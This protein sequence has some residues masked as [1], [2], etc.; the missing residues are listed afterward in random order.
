MKRA[1]A[2]LLCM[3]LA[4]ADF[5]NAAKDAGLTSIV[6]N[7]GTTSKQFIIE[8]TGSGVAF[9]DYDNDGLQDIFV[10]SG[11]DAPSRMYHNEGGGKFRDVT[12][13]L[14]LTRKGWGQGVCAGDFDNDGFTDIFV[15]Y[16]GQNAL[17]HNT[18][19][20]HFEDVTA[21]AHL[22]QG[23]ARYN[24][25]CAFLDY[26]ND[27]KLDLFVSNYLKFDFN[28]TPKPGANPYCFY[29]GIAVNC[30]PRGL[31][32]DRNLLYHSEGG[33]LFK[34]VSD[35]SGMS[36]PD[37]NYSLGVLTADFNGDGLTDIYVACDQTPSILY[38][39]LGNG[40]FAD[41]ALMRGTALDENG[42]AMSGMGVAAA[43]YMHQGLQ[44]IF[45]TNF[46]DELETL[47]RNRGKG[48]FE[49]V[50]VESGLGQNTRFVG[51]GCGFFDF[52]NDGWPDLLLVNGHAFPEVDKLNIDIHYRERAILYRN[53]K[54]HFVD[55]SESSG[56][57]IVEK[58]SSRGAAFGDYDN[59][60]AI[61]VLVNN[62]GEAPSLL[63]QAA[64]TGNHWITL[65]LEGVQANRSAIGARV[66]VTAG[67]LIQ[68]GEVRS[69][70]SYLSQNDLR[71]HFGLGG[72]VKVD[73]VEITWP[74]GKQQLETDLKSDRVT[75][76]RERF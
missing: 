16:W 32:F 47:Y 20:K 60:G 29:R 25:G 19:G 28:T 15:T 62:Q 64:S 76:I 27:G 21:K 22:T 12:E 18:G 3:R 5:R 48:E 42:K 14:G 24:T 30:G 49:D 59:D 11:P 1:A 51:W 33:G 46:S 26:D 61:E 10:V 45:R 23:R 75:N 35:E 56:T 69:G 73:K 34:D 53:E 52:D 2:V 17:Y 8:T 31:P 57:G 68:T 36:K 71:L 43:D 66:R 74:G 63:R 50:S 72:A 37:G 39:N 9:I 40:K 70:G 55:V 4:A 6:P 13:I 38:I 65:K 41:E 44:S 54:G 7:G 58:H 67:S